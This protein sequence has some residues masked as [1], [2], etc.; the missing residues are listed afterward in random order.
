[1]LRPMGVL[2][3]LSTTSYIWRAEDHSF[4]TNPYLTFTFFLDRLLGLN[5]TFHYISAFG[6]GGNS[7]VAV[8]FTQE[9]LKYFGHHSLFNLFINARNI[10]VQ[11][12]LRDVTIVVTS[13]SFTV[14]S[15][16][17]TVT[18]TDTNTF[19]Q[20][21]ISSTLFFPHLMKFMNFCHIQ[22]QK[23]QIVVL[24]LN[25][26][27][28]NPAILFDGPGQ[29]STQIQIDPTKKQQ[30]ISATAFQAL[31]VT[32]NDFLYNQNSTLPGST[33]LYHGKGNPSRKM[34]TILLPETKHLHMTWPP[35]DL[36]TSSPVCVVNFKTSSQKRFKISYSNWDYRGRD[37]TPL[38]SYAGISVFDTFNDTI[39]HKQTQCVHM[40]HH[41]SYFYQV[42]YFSQTQFIHL[43][44]SEFQKS[45]T[46]K[47][48]DLRN[49]YSTTNN[50]ML[51]WYSFKEYGSMSVDLNITTTSCDVRIHEVTN[52]SRTYCEYPL[53]ALSF[54]NCGILKFI[55][56]NDS[57]LRVCFK[58]LTERDVLKVEV[59]G[60]FRGNSCQC[61]TAQTDLRRT[62]LEFGTFVFVCLCLCVCVCCVCVSDLLSHFVLKL[63]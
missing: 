51:V 53:S 34:K 11:V 1:M 19:H 27:M 30:A 35:V 39:S 32:T 42:L 26:S 22:V 24:K 40:N 45:F 38:C 63:K 5:L 57:H 37:S 62:P 3:L 9:Y 60:H 15:Q 54:K 28:E 2:P 31:V 8:Q 61:V 55:F 13:M 29:R 25:P 21:S 6:Q 49:S 20:G 46:P 58:D 56:Q 52:K 18:L 14:I 7:H 17:S 44:N 23:F 41:W 43:Y 36:C 47:K 33:V 4:L 48:A 16:N 12:I 50:L 59:T 10:S